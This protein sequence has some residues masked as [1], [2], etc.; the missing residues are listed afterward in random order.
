MMLWEKRKS[1]L[2]IDRGAP[3]S[4]YRPTALP[5][6]RRAA[7]VL[8]FLACGLSACERA[9]PDTS[10]GVSWELAEHRASTI[11]EVRYALTFEIPPT[12]NERIRGRETI[13][14]ELSDSRHPVVLDFVAPVED[15]IAVRSSGS[16]AQHE[17]TNEHVVVPAAA[18]REGRNEIEIEFLAGDLSLNRNEEFLYTLF[19]PDRARTAFPCFD[20]P[21]LKAVYALT[22]ETPVSWKAVANAPSS[23]ADTVGGRAIHRFADTRPLSTYLFAFAAGEFR[24]E[25][26]ERDGRTMHMYHR[27]TDT[28]KVARNREAV[29]DLH[30]AALRWLEDYTG[31]PYP[32]QKFDFVLIPS[33]QYGGMEHAGAILYRSS[34]ILLDETATQSQLLGRAGVISHETAH[35]W[36]GDLVTMNW[37][38]DVW[39]KEVFAGF[40]SS[41]IVN[42]SFPAIN[43]E[44]RFF[45]SNYPTAYGVDRTA[46][47]NPIRQPLENLKDAGTLY[48]AIIYQ[49]APIVMRQLESL[50]GEET[51]RDG[52][53]EYLRA[54]EYGNATWPDLIA[55]LDEL[56]EQ[57]LA[58]WSDVWVEEPG[59]PTVSISPIL[60]DR[61]ELQALELRQSDPAGRDRLW[62]QSIQVAVAWDGGSRTIPAL[63]NSPSSRVPVE[64]GVPRPR[65]VLGA[66]GGIGY[67]L[68]VTDDSTRH[69]LLRYLPEIE[70]PLTRAVA[71]VTLWDALLEGELAP[72]DLLDLV[73]RAL[74]Q[75]NEE[76][77][78]QQILGYLD[79]LYWKFTLS[80]I[81]LQLAPAVEDL[82][83]R[84][85][86]QAE[87]TSLKSEYFSSYT[88]LA[89]SDEAIGRL[90]RLWEQRADIPGLPLFE[91]DYIRLAEAL[92]LREVNG[93]QEILAA[94][95]ER[96]E[97][98]DRRASFE[99]AMP[100]L[101]A[102]QSVRDEFFESLKDPANREHEPW[103]LSGVSFLHHELRAESAEKYIIPSLELLEEIQ[104]TGD[105]FFPQRW[106]GATLGGHN[107]PAAVAMVH[108]FLERRPDYPYRLRLKI[109]QSADLLERAA[110]IVYGAAAD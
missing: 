83:W 20:Q 9:G 48:G 96:I 21:N 95:L 91:R 45:L 68:F 37:F 47:A 76:L 25:S 73:L 24:M 32:F 65:Y 7:Q 29:F 106:L 10:P 60:D 8:L 17:V 69:Y 57:D 53:R 49:K 75:E 28:R 93:Y 3:F 77:N 86:Q 35:M 82:L 30:A 80:D 19:V 1:L 64:P 31:V 98:P 54:F 102:D 84:L 101:S 92:A 22:L 63:L 97:N 103:V 50:I 85:L 23:E 42:P 107:T 52:M 100:A 14:F 2:D 105:I 36:F 27:E 34:S 4:A 16:S 46:G 87:S 94:Q 5:P 89:L 88:A 13:T 71:W 38:D 40:M 90:R 56:S 33:F 58:S 79:T 39:T 108:A 18:L 11:S 104:R 55:I 99:F 67:G 44:Q 6:Y 70:H 59:R 41:K 81:R 62:V 110:R 26:A 15:V 43:H 51:F 12:L 74:P 72:Q 66:G 61:G 109:L 78:V